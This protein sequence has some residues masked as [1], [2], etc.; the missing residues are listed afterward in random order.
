[1]SL[2]M[3]REKKKTP[4]LCLTRHMLREDRCANGDLFLASLGTLN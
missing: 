2:G 4:L 3:L 1:M